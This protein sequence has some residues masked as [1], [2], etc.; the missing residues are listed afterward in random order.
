MPYRVHG[1]LGHRIDERQ[2]RQP[3]KVTDSARAAEAKITI[4]WLATM[5]TAVRWWRRHRV[6][7]GR[8]C[9]YAPS[10]ARTAYGYLPA[11]GLRRTEGQGM[12][13][14]VPGCVT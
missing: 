1:H 6:V 12:P 11:P 7:S 13:S 8:T 2:R 10:P 14:T 9:I 5:T 4:S 3:A